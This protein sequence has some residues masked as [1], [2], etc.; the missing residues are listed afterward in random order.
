MSDPAWAFA[1]LLL[2][3]VAF[4]AACL[5]SVKVADWL[6]LGTVKLVRALRRSPNK[7]R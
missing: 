2:F 1:G 3:L 7:V 6:S 4:P 5:L